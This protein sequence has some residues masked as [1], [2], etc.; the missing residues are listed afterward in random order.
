V[1]GVVLLL[2]IA[3]AASTAPLGGSGG[4][5]GT[6]GE[7]AP[8]RIPTAWALVLMLA[9]LGVAMVAVLE[10]VRSHPPRRHERE[11]LELHGRKK[12]PPGLQ[13]VALI[14]S[15]LAAAVLINLVFGA[16]GHEPLANLGGPRRVRAAGGAGAGSAFDLFPWLPFALLTLLVAADLVIIAFGFLPIGRGRV[17]RR[18]RAAPDVRAAVE[19]SLVDLRTDPDPRRAVIAAYRRMEAALAAAGLRRRR[20]EAPRE[21]MGRALASLELSTEPLMTLTSIFEYARFS[22]WQIDEPARARAIAALSDMREELE[23]LG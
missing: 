3:A 14:V 9:A 21:Y 10:Y 17:V 7:A 19:R 2:G 6:A 15:I 20:A 18:A 5:A 12:A 22:L 23:T 11:A 4:G 13:F 1:V 8:A 16:S